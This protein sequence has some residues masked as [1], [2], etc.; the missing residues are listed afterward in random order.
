M[1]ISI[2][3]EITKDEKRVAATPETVR[4]LKALGAEVYVESMAGGLS[5]FDDAAFANAGAKICVNPR[6]VYENADLVLKV[7]APLNEELK[8]IKKGAIIIAHFNTLQNKESLAYLAQKDLTCLAMDL[9][10]RIS[11]AQSMD[12]LSSQSN[13]AGYRAVIEGVYQLRRAVPVSSVWLR[14]LLV[15]L[16]GQGVAACGRMCGGR[17]VKR[18]F[19][20]WRYRVWGYRAVLWNIVSRMWQI[21]KRKNLS[22]T[23]KYKSD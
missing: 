16:R 2:P 8:L 15:W 5:G 9:I 23:L 17:G 20:V 13:L 14:A 10:P 7:N 18:K 12:V 11:R 22:F 19:A 3:K 21:S 4:K 1:I 6:D